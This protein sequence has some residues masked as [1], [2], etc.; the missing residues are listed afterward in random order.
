MQLS[1]RYE[2]YQQEEIT[3]DGE[4]YNGVEVWKTE[5]LKMMFV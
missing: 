5:S 3:H 4:S 2:R 1:E